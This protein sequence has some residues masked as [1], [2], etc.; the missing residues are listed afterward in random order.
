MYYGTLIGSANGT[1]ARSWRPLTRKR[2]G[3]KCPRH[4]LGSTPTIKNR[5]HAMIDTRYAWTGPWRATV[6]MA[7]TA[8]RVRDEGVA[9]S[10]PVSPTTQNAGQPPS[11]AAPSS[12]P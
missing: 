4:K 5:Q 2:S 6:G 8:N 1:P 3:G 7:A 11:P 12:S 10:N 9:G